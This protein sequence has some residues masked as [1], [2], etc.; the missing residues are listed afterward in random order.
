MLDAT[1]YK[2][3]RCFSHQLNVPMPVSEQASLLEAG[4]RSLDALGEAGMQV[5]RRLD[6]DPNAV[7]SS[8]KC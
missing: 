1:W 6:L 5:R 8:L 7:L 2:K 3:T 4:Y